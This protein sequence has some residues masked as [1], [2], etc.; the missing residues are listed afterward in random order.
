MAVIIVNPKNWDVPEAGVDVVQVDSDAAENIAAIGD[1][2]NWCEQH[3]FA[4]VNQYWLRTIVRPDGKRVF[5]GVCYRLTDE[6]RQ[7]AEA[8]NREHERQVMQMPVTP[9]RA[10]ESR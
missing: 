2:E 7:S 4:R 5:R 3:G 8:A 1:I 10:G 6:E 9:H